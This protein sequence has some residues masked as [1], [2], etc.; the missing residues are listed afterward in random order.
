MPPNPRNES[1]ACIF[2]QAMITTQKSRDG[3]WK[4]CE[5]MCITCEGY[6]HE[7]SHLYWEFGP[8]QVIILLGSFEQL[9]YLLFCM[10]QESTKG[11]EDQFEL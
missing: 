11:V 9:R 5:S 10:S 6:I 4:A 7:L 2:S 3:F 1:Y 8:S